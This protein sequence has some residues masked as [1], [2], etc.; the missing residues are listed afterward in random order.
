MR[1]TLRPRPMSRAAVIM[2]TLVVLCL[3][4]VAPRP[5]RAAGL[6]GVPAFGHVFVLV[7]ENTSFSE[8]TPRHAPYITG[9]LRPQAA[10][11]TRYFALTDGSLGD[12]AAMVSGQFVRCE[13][14]DDFSFTNGDVPGQHACHQNVDNLFHQLDVRRISWR[15]WTE[16]AANPCDMFDHG[17]TWARNLFSAHHSPALYFDDVQAHHSSEDVVPSPE[18]R[19]DVL[20][21]GTTGPDDTTAF[22]AALGAGAVGRFNLVIP[23]D[24]ENGHDLCGT[25]DSVRQFDDFVA[26]EVPKIEASPAFGADG[27]IVVVWD[28]GADPPRSPLHVGALLLGPHITPGLVVRRRLTHYSLLRTLEDGFAITRHLAHAAKAPAITGIWR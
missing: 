26:R 4:A 7:G 6:D 14:N 22:D 5:A 21:T 16:S 12:Y 10:W 17:A 18:C 27:L 19:R 2:L 28:E 9:V 1:A 20:P 15:E 3:G 24:C 13:R 8:V 23:N 25:H 11:L